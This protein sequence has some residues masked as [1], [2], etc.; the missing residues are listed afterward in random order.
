MIKTDKEKIRHTQKYS[1]LILVPGNSRN[2]AT[3]T[4]AL[5]T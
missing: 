2:I 4:L 1:E 5:P 3:V